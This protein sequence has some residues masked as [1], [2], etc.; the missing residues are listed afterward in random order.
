MLAAVEVRPEHAVRVHPRV[1]PGLDRPEAA[2]ALTLDDLRH[3]TTAVE[4]IDAATRAVVFTGAGE[5]VFC[6]GMH[7]ETFQGLT[8]V[9][10]RAVI[11]QVG[12]FLAAVRHS[13]VVTVV[14]LNGACL[15]VACEL[16]L[17]CDLRVARTGTMVGLPEVKLGIP[18]VVDAAL[19]P[20]YVGLSRARE[21]ILTGDSVPVEELGESFANRIVAPSQLRAE[22]ERLQRFG[23]TLADSV[24]DAVTS[25]LQQAQVTAPVEMPAAPA[26]E[27]AAPAAHAPE[28]PAVAETPAEPAESLFH[29]TVRQAAYPIQRFIGMYWA[30]LGPQP[31]PLIPQFDVWVR[32]DGRRRLYQQ[33]QLD[34]NWVQ[35]M[36][37]SVDPAHLYW[38]HGTLGSPNMPV[39]AERFVAL[40]LQ[41]EYEEKNEFFRFDYGIQKRRTTLGHGPGEFGPQGPGVA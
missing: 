31:A 9:T 4:T 24:R 14:M 11:T 26:V 2:N 17:A 15:G 1:S 40:G 34:C 8:P 21:M 12:D 25:A 37:N 28:V 39:S 27:A 10:A 38:L 3:L 36:E 20:A 18:S 35:A 32:K 13:P 16:A 41:P 30:Y 5:R 7:L 19:L 6:A 33:P 29:L 23:E 22:T